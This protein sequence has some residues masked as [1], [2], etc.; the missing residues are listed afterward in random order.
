VSDEWGIE[1]RYWTIDGREQHVSPETVD[2]LRSIIDRPP[3]GW[4]PPVLVVRPHD[5]TEVGPARMVL[6]DGTELD[7]HHSLPDGLPLGYHRLLD[8][9]GERRLIVS[10]GRC[11]L[12][13]GWRAWGWAVQLYAARS[14]S[15]WGMGDLADLGRLNR[16]SAG[17]LGAGFCLVS[18]L[19]AV[20]PVIPQES[21]PY[22]PSS[23][24]FRNPIY[25]RVEDVPGASEL[26]SDLDELAAAG[27]ALNDDRVIDRD[28]VWRLKLDALER[29]W[30][31]VGAG[32]DFERWW[33]DRPPAVEEF[34]TWCV[35][36]EEHGPNWRHWPEPVRQPWAPGVAEAAGRNAD[37]AR[38]H[39]WLQWL[40]D[41]QLRA[42][43]TDLVVLQ[44]LPIGVNP[45]GADA[46]AWQGVLADG[47][48]V[49]APPD[50][51]NRQGQDWGLPPFVP[52]RLQDA[53]YQP[54]IDTIR[55]TISAAGGLRVDHVMGLFR[56]WWVPTGSP[57]T[58]GAYV[59]YPSADLL[60]IVA[61]ESHLA[62]APVVGED[63]GTVEGGVRETMAERNML[64][65]KVLWFEPDDPA[66]WPAGSMAAVTTH[67]LPTV[68]GIWSGHDLEE[69]Q[70]AGLDPNR[71]DTERI[72]HRLTVAGDLDPDRDG[73]ADAVVAAHRLLARA[74]SVLLGATLDD[75]IAEPARPNLPGADQAR[76]LNWRL[77]LPVALDDLPHLDLPRRLAGI[78][79][80]AVG[81][82]PA[83]ADA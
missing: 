59:R 11:H 47:V 45:D 55:A 52:W 22:F 80:E 25:L 74:P 15:S 82:P 49:G 35:L 4:R 77:A 62:E 39:G 71:D 28:R 63:L 12:P 65:Y 20:A 48:S 10:P 61:L 17:S 27:R 46:W 31:R 32:P 50:A 57:P 73:D 3:D 8:A 67:D 29:I 33:A 76:P 79:G 18:P 56:L 30:A 83:G 34:T 21:S 40:T 1:H 36:V 24:R 75:A 54:F 6:D 7:V 41:A 14:R 44:D 2:R 68:A 58:D 23:R 53:G 5:R 60:D 16:W 66:A 19:H 26:G 43:S 37:R 9:H 70:A 38:F 69:Q 13:E 81:R 42:A 78:L 72:R 51:F 64:T